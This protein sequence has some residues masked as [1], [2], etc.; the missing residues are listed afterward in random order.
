MH[1]SIHQMHKCKLKKYILRFKILSLHHCLRH[2]YYASTDPNTELYND[3]WRSFLFH[4]HSEHWNHWRTVYYPSQEQPR[5][6]CHCPPHPA[7]EDG[8]KHSR[9]RSVD[10]SLWCRLWD[11]YHGHH[12]RRSSGVHW[13]ELCHT[14]T[15]RLS[16][17]HN[18][19]Q[20]VLLL[21]LSFS[22]LGIC[23]FFCVMM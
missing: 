3:T 8:R 23:F 4:L 19:H 1:C 17:K 12:R 22:V 16:C 20:L 9:N 5:F 10:G 18:V 11:W 7:F 2:I 21:H 15:H 14:A 13:P 6:Q